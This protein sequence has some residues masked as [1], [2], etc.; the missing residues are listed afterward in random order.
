MEHKTLILTSGLHLSTFTTGLLTEE[1]LLPLC[2][3]TDASISFLYHMV[4]IHYIYNTENS[5]KSQT[6]FRCVLFK[7]VFNHANNVLAESTFILVCHFMWL[8]HMFYHW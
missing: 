7:V 8:H 6:Y 1:A 2:Q 4:Y 3:L 5:N